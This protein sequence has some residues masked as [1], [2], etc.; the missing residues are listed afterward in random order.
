MQNRVF[1]F[2]ATF[3]IH[4]LIIVAFYFSFFKKSKAPRT[5]TVLNIS[6]LGEDVEQKKVVK[7][8]NY[9]EHFAVTKDQQKN[10]QHTHSASDA[11][12]GEVTKKVAPIFNP[13][14]QIP[15]DLREE[16]FVSEAIA[17]F[18]IDATGTVT[19]VDLIKPCANPRLNNLLLKS[20]KSWKFAAVKRSSTQ[21][22]R[23][24]FKVE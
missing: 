7:E 3:L 20:L 2:L 24:N 19:R 1:S 5:E 21:D 23:V 8:L 18:Y 4:L 6:T 16:A 15:N 17:R 14:P 22:I 12:S 10:S 13:L 9:D 11:D